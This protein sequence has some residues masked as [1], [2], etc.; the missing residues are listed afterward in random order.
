MDPSLLFRLILVIF[1]L[2]LSAFFSGSETALF[3]INKHQMRRFETSNKLSYQ[4]AYSLLKNPKNLIITLLIGNECVN[5]AISV[6]ITSIVLS[7]YGNVY[8]AII[9][10]SVLLLIFAETVPKTIGIIF[11]E[12]FS[13]LASGPL[14]LFSKLIRPLRKGLAKFADLVVRQFGFQLKDLGYAITEDE[15]RT[16]VDVG[17]DEG[18]LEVEE[19]ELIHKVFEFG[20]TKVSEVMTPRTDIFS[21]DIEEKPEEIF[22]KCKDTL[23]SRIPVYE[24][25]LDKIVG[26]LYIK[27]L[28]TFYRKD[29]KEF[30]LKEF[31]HSPYFIPE[32]KNVNELLKEFQAN[33]IH[34]A[35][36]MDEY[37]GISGLVTMEDL[38]EELVGEIIDE[39][40]EEENLIKKVDENIYKV[41]AMMP[42]DEF[43]EMMNCKIKSK[44]F[45]TIGGYVFYLFGKLPKKGD[46]ISFDDFVFK[47]EKMEGTRI[48]ELKVE[49]RI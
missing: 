16:L 38:L 18:V 40:D 31:L 19:K 48:I 43:N 30:K 20:D 49:R 33:K 23:F 17:H 42:I 44:D 9:I 3:S 5:V 28:L 22:L 12:R 24:E 47:V 39:F 6:T 14:S 15:F 10:G 46:L 21:I 11:P 13:Q 7:L 2:L 25:S 26:I 1:L 41:S 35:I 8:L 4:R 32:T 45:D 27:D 29:V 36:L 37:G 34:M